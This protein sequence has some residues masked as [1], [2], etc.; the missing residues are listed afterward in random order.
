MGLLTLD[1]MKNEVT[2]NLG[3]R[4]DLDSYLTT[5]INL[6][7]RR[8]AR[9]HDWEELQRTKVDANSATDTKSYDAATFLGESSNE[10]IRDIHTLRLIDGTNSK[11][12]T[13]LTAARLDEVLARPENSSSGKPSYYVWYGNYLELI[14]IPDATYTFYVRHSLYPETMAN[15]ASTSDLKNKDDAIIALTTSWCFSSLKMKEEAAHWF[16]IGKDLILNALR[17][18]QTDRDLKLTATSEL[19][20]P[21]GE[22]WNDPFQK[23]AP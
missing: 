8:I 17:E 5:R 1:Q 6:Q 4:T 2:A 12:L 11:R 7:C 20:A 16:T 14:K 10:N 18:D 21:T 15:G 3:G 19:K 22:Y 23:E 13:R 9:L